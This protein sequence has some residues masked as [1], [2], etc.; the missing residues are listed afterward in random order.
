MA[1]FFSDFE[2]FAG[3]IFGT[4]LIRCFFS[5][6]KPDGRRNRKRKEDFPV[7]NV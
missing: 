7:T 3:L 4:D 2:R 5:L 1:D 6:K